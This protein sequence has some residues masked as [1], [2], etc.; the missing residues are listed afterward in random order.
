MSEP[1][2]RV[3]RGHRLKFEVLE[4]LAQ[5][6]AYAVL[7]SAYV[8]PWGDLMHEIK[9][10]IERG[11]DVRLIV[12]E[13][14]G[15]KHEKSKALAAIEQFAALGVRVERV[16]RLHAKVYLNER[17]VI[18]TSFNLVSASQDSV[19]LGMASSDPAILA[20][21][22]DF[23]RVLVPSLADVGERRATPAVGEAARA[24]ADRAAPGTG[25][26]IGCADQ[27]HAFDPTKPLCKSCYKGSSRG[28]KLDALP[29][30]V[31]HSCGADHP[32]T[33]EKP[34]CYPCWKAL[35]A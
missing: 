19:E 8:A 24:P 33:I 27:A 28:R 1:T 17:Q 7:A 22:L 9:V 5:A 18:L 13:P 34:V 25:F 20:E 26:C 3:L 6:Q 16:E 32:A 21:C 23:L 2:T 31:C 29:K 14:D 10:A 4:V 12:R 11:V 30:R 15:R 35:A